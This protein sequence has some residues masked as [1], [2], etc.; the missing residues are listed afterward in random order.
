[1]VVSCLPIVDPHSIMKHPFVNSIFQAQ[2]VKSNWSLK[3]TLGYAKV[4]YFQR[5][6]RVV[7]NCAKIKKPFLLF[8]D[9][10][11]GEHPKPEQNK[12]K[13]QI[14]RAITY[15]YMPTV[16]DRFMMVYDNP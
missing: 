6:M 15:G 3:S 5:H 8:G 16:I 14:G 7:T 11:H 13:H 9:V 12:T 1:M 4:W 2:L 10:N